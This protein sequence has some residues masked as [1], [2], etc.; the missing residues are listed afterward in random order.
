MT[1]L[2]GRLG[3]LLDDASTTIASTPLDPGFPAV[4]AGRRRR[5][6]RITVVTML[7]L[8]VAGTGAAV[9]QLRSDGTTIRTDVADT[10]ESEER[11]EDGAVDPALDDDEPGTGVGA[12]DPATP[13][14]QAAG[15][16]DDGLPADT[17]PELVWRE[18]GG[19]T[20]VGLGFGRLVWSGERFVA[21]AYDEAFTSLIAS[22]DGETWTELAPLPGGV[23]ALDL[24]VTDGRLIAWG[25][26]VDPDE[27]PPDSLL[28]AASSGPSRI[29]VSDDHGESWAVLTELAEPADANESDDAV[30]VRQV[31]GAELV[32]DRLVAA[33]IRQDQVDLPRLL[34][35]RGYDVD[36]TLSGYTISH[37]DEF[38]EGSIT[39]CVDASCTE[40][41][42][43]TFAELDLSDVEIA[44][45]E[46]EGASTEI[47]VSVAGGPLE[48]TATFDGWPQALVETNGDLILSL[49]ADSGT[50]SSHRSVDGGATW[51]PM[52]GPPEIGSLAT[53]GQWVFATTADGS[54][55]RSADGGVGWETIDTGTASVST[56]AGGPSGVVV[57]ATV[58][59]DESTAGSEALVVEVDGYIVTLDDIA[60]VVDAATG[61]LVLETGPG[62]P[63]GEP[64]DGV[65]FTEEPWSIAFLDPETGEVIVEIDEADVDVAAQEDGSF[66]PPEEVIGWS[67][68]GE[69]WGWQTA[70]EAFGVEGGYPQVAVGDGRVVAWV[71]TFDGV[72]TDQGQ[73]FV[74]DIG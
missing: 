11:D 29:L 67:A 65:V 41:V 60:T 50:P 40:E 30:T 8:V 25:P 39:F 51:T 70:T 45:L 23:T 73:W 32:D 46:G 1:D 61:E 16:P 43:L 52:V 38:N 19:P 57:S 68:D 59:D 69:R 33:A 47:W 66:D 72:S 34:G 22:V 55:E 74:A 27:V 48:L 53:V 20:D 63:D 21:L 24:I 4:R 13:D 58:F 15:A 37:R 62:G 14:D 5:N 9:T 64:P 6:R 18:V 54:F 10:N 12:D 44:A 26:V 49:F 17:G 31:I 35:D 7:L 28:T 71:L 56:V 2:E 36:A 42:E 3:R